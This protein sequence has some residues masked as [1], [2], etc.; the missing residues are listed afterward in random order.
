MKA[1][2]SSYDEMTMSP[3]Q[4]QARRNPRVFD[5]SVKERAD[6]AAQMFASFLGQSKKMGGINV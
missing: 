6:A 2:K 5:C 4:I 3:E 1:L